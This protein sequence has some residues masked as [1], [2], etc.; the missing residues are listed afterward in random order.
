MIRTLLPLAALFLASGCTDKTA[1]TPKRPDSPAVAPGHDS[2]ASTPHTTDTTKSDTAKTGAT[3]PTGI[4][5]DNDSIPIRTPDGGVAR[6]GLESGRVNMVYSGH[7]KGGRVV[8]WDGWGKRE[9]RETFRQP[10]PETKPAG[11]DHSIFITNGE[12]QTYVSIL[13]K[14]AQHRHTGESTKMYFASP[15]ASSRSFG[16]VM[17]DATG[18]QRLADTTILG[19][20]CHVYQRTRSGMTTTLAM[21]RGIVLREEVNN[22]AQDLRFVL[23]AV[24]LSPNIT[25]PESAFTAPTDFPI[26]EAK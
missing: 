15:E 7:A 25:V 9:R 16:G 21:W 6:Y 8:V 14:K 3:D 2:V 22:P 20:R 4:R 5:W 24:E 26:E 23:E 12:D 17:V 13:Q 19:R 18:A 10:E 11:F 1:D